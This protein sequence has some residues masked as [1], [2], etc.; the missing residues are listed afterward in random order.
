MLGLQYITFAIIFVTRSLTASAIVFWDMLCS[1]S[2][3]L[4]L[5]FQS[6]LFS[7]LSQQLEVQQKVRIPYIFSEIKF[8]VDVFCIECA[9]SEALS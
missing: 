2:I 9:L 6:M 1:L 8:H 3:S 4:V 5:I 7:R